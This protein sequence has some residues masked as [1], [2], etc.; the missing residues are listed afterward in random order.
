MA[1]LYPPYIEGALPAFCLSNGDG[2]LVIPFA[3]NRAISNIED[4][5]SFAIKI[6][7]VQNDVL[8]GDVETGD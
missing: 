6:K 8:L 7:T 3:H 2:E 5:K 4:I 1:K